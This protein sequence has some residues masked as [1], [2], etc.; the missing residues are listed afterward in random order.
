MITLLTFI[1]ESPHYL[2]MKGDKDRAIR[3]LEWLRSTDNKAELEEELR[4]IV[5]SSSPATISTDGTPD[6][7]FKTS[8][9]ALVLVLVMGTCQIFSG[10]GALEAYAS[11]AF[12]MDGN[13]SAIALGLVALSSDLISAVIIDRFGRRP[14][15]LVSCV[16]CG[17]SHAAAAYGLFLGQQKLTV[18]GALAGAMFFANAGIMPL[19][20]TIVCEYFPTNHRAQANGIVQFAMTTASL[21]SLKIYQPITNTYGVHANYVLFSAVAVFSAVFVYWFIPETKGKTFKEIEMLFRDKK[22]NSKGGPNSKCSNGGQDNKGFE[23]GKNGHDAG[24]DSKSIEANK[25][26]ED[27]MGGGGDWS[28]CCVTIK[29]EQ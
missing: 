5:T 18:L 24:K 28:C 6:T 14:L 11:S 16:G 17:I 9:R 22:Y 21:V 12:E 19:V 23:N 20:T 25:G 3:S 7:L 1:P 26:V 13:G 10:I 15:L 2:I 27:N 29:P 8:G 4:S